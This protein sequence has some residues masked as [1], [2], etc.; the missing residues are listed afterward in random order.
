MKYAD[1]QEVESKVFLGWMALLFKV[2]QPE[3]YVLNIATRHI[4]RRCMAG[5]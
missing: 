4:I 5:Q 2:K 3:P 1:Y